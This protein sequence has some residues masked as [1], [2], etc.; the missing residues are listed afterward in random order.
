MGWGLREGRQTIDLSSP[1][2]MMPL[3][4]KEDGDGYEYLSEQFCSIQS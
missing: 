3:C 1:Q 4:F 2:H